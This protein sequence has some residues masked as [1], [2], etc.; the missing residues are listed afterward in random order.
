MVVAGGAIALCGMMFW[1]FRKEPCGSRPFN[2]ALVVA[3]ALTML[4][5]PTAAGANYNQAI[6]L[7]AAVWLFTPGRSLAK[8]GLARLMWV[9]AV[10]TLAWEWILALPVS[11]AAF[12]LQHR[13]EREATWFVAGPELVTFLFPLALALFLLCV[14]PQVLRSRVGRAP[15]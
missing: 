4:C 10:N 8:G 9:M 7:P 12:A 1:R 6:L 13:F 5:L 14:A 2:Y 15:S 3:L 11:F